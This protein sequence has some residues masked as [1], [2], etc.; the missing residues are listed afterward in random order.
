MPSR[1]AYIKAIIFCCSSFLFVAS[2]WSQPDNS[3]V[4]LP[5]TPTAAAFGKFIEATVAGHTGV[6]DISIP[7]HTVTTGPLSL[8]ISLRYN[9]SGIK[10]SEVASWV[11]IGW[12]LT[13]GGVISRTVNGLPDE[14]TNG[15][16]TEASNI[17]LSGFYAEQVMLGNKDSE[18]DIFSFSIPGYA[19]KMLFDENGDVYTIP[20][21]PLK[22][23]YACCGVSGLKFTISDPNGTRYIFGTNTNSTGFVDGRELSKNYVPTQQAPSD[24]V[25]S[26]MLIRMESYDEKH[27]IEFDYTLENIEYHMPGQSTYF[28]YTP[29]GSTSSNANLTNYVAS[30]RRLTAI[31]TNIGEEITF[32]A[33]TVRDDVGIS[34]Q[35]PDAHALDAITI[36]EGAYATQWVFSYDY[37]EDPDQEYAGNPVAKRLRLTQIQQKSLDNSIEIPPYV[38]DYSKKDGAYFLPQ[39]LSKAKDYWGYYNARTGNEN[40]LV[41]IPTTSIN[42]FTCSNCGSNRSSALNVM[43]YGVLEKITYPTGGWTEFTFEENRYKPT[44]SSPLLPI[45]TQNESFGVGYLDLETC[46]DRFGVGCCGSNNDDDDLTLS[47]IEDIYVELFLDRTVQDD[48]TCGPSIEETS[49]LFEVFRT[50]DDVLMGS[51]NLGEFD[52]EDAPI[53]R[54]KILKLIDLIPSLQNSV[55]YTYKLTSEDAYGTATLY[56][57]SY[58]IT[59]VGSESIGD[60]NVV[61]GLRAQEIRHYDP[62]QENEVVTTYEYSDGIL[63]QEY[64]TYAG[65]ISG[66]LVYNP[67]SGF[68]QGNNI[69][70]AYFS[71]IPT[72]P[73]QDLSGEHVGYEEI[74]IIQA[75]G[76]KKTR[77][78]LLFPD[79]SAYTDG[80]QSYN[81]LVDATSIFPGEIPPSIEIDNGWN[82]GEEMYKFGASTPYSQTSLVRNT[83]MNFVPEFTTNLKFYRSKALT[84]QVSTPDPNATGYLHFQYVTNYYS[85]WATRPSSKTSMLDGVSIVEAYQYDT[86]DNH[87]F[88]TEVHTANSDGSVWKQISTYPFDYVDAVNSER[89]TLNIIQPP[90]EVQILNDADVQVDGTHKNFS[91]FDGST[92]EV[93]GGTG[94]GPYL[95]DVERY[96]VSWD[97]NGTL[98]GSAQYNSIATIDKIDI[99]NGFPTEITQRGWQVD[100]F[101][102]NAD[103]NLLA[104]RSFG[105]FDW[106]YEY[107]TDTRLLSKVTDPDKQYTTFDYD[108]LRRLASSDARLGNVSTAYDY[109]YQESGSARNFI[110][111]TTTFTTVTGSQLSSLMDRNYLDGL[112]RSIQKIAVGQSPDQKDVIRAMTYDNVGRTLKE[113]EPYENSSASGAYV[114]IVTLDNANVDFTQYGYEDGPTN[115]VTE[116]TPPGWYTTTTSYGANSNQITVPG[117]SPFGLNTLF[118][119]TTTDPD[120]RVSISYKDMRGRLVLSRRNDTGSAPNIDTY[121]DYDDKDRLRTVYPPATSISTDS[122][123][124]EYVYDDRDN[125]IFKKIPDQDGMHYLYNN[126]NLLTFSQDGNMLANNHWLHTKYDTYGRPVSTGFVNNGNFAD[127]GSN[128][129]YNEELS[130]SFYDGDVGAADI[131]T[132]KI[133]KSEA[134]ILGTT[135]DW[136]STKFDYDPYGRVITTEAKNHLN[137]LDEDS[138]VVNMSYDFADNILSQNRDHKGYV[139]SPLVEIDES[140]TY[141]HA[142]RNTGHSLNLNNTGAIQLCALEYTIKNELKRKKMGGT[143][144]DFL[145]YVDYHYLPNGFLDRINDFSLTATGEPDDLFHL[146]LRYNEASTP[147]DVIAQKNGNISQV[148]WRVSG[149]NAKAY[150]FSYDYLNRLE[151]ANY[152]A[153]QNGTSTSLQSDDAYSSM[154]EY[155]QR[156]NIEWLERHGL[157][158]DGSNFTPGIIDDLDHKYS[159]TSNRLVTIIASG[160]AGFASLGFDDQGQ[161]GVYTYDKN[162][163]MQ[164]DPFKQLD[165]DYNHLNL[166]E[167]ITETDDSG[168]I[169]WLYDASGT[170]L[171][172]TTETSILALSG[173][174]TSGNYEAEEI[175]ASGIIQ[176]GSIVSFVADNEITLLPGFTTKSGSEFTA[177]LAPTGPTVHDYINGIE[178]R[179]GTLE[180]IYHDQGRIYFHNGTPRF[181][182]TITDHLGNTRVTFADLNDDDQVDETEVLQENHYYPFGLEML[183]DWNVHPYKQNQYQYNGKELNEDLG[184]NWLDYGARWY[185]PAIARWNAV[186]PLAEKM[187]NWS[188]YNYTY[189]NPIRFIDPIGMAPFGDLYNQSGKKIGTDNKDDGRV[190]VVT[191]KKTIKSLKKSGGVVADASQVNSAIELPTVAVRGEMG[192]AVDR[193]NSRNDNRTDE[194]QGDDNEG[195]FHEEGGVYGKDVDGNYQVIHAKPGAKTEPDAGAMA[196]VAPDDPANP[197]APLIVREGSF[198]VHPSGTR[199][200][201]SST[202][203]G[204][205]RS[206]NQNPTDP[207]DFNEASNYPGNSYVLGAKGT[208]TIINGSGKLATFPLKK[209]IN[210]GNGKK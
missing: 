190:F 171:R 80:Y 189:N 138:E 11:G 35:S 1:S 106:F 132:G 81:G 13:A 102:Y 177:N 71:D 30:T 36:T 126:R 121:Y 18:Q 108:V 14:E 196:T 210:I 139:A 72:F 133:W 61:G 137:L 26:W 58:N 198:H 20:K 119:E 194:F 75:D 128:P 120:N 87:P 168:S 103:N 118:K 60:E 181:E 46:L 10:V 161:T 86:N 200:P 4:S 172:K 23:E 155:D 68:V 101:T 131:F 187:S 199:S 201:G 2:I 122:L 98:N 165:I 140:W 124:Y 66:S 92:G 69:S 135:S 49:I 25:S 43:Q 40:N 152:G 33:N 105:D 32:T 28:D 54:T 170:K 191:D 16:L 197:N 12:N 24:I 78:F 8:P 115:R 209:F 150:G 130:R 52:I 114:S 19:G 207:Q 176:D 175:N 167:N 7:I 27:W 204:Q 73:L 178:Y 44:I 21:M 67:G 192:K 63:F 174:I 182:Y 173:I 146:D 3:Y 22:I 17:S 62:V 195:G 157:K 112:G 202:I 57:P 91:F 48:G 90:V 147:L 193:S 159:S 9:A 65:Q 39:R 208:V 136:L 142:G 74:H 64:P 95:A 141:D 185:D 143:G 41:N 169:E 188:P 5:P 153:Y 148:H 117:F 164:H 79:V 145:Q 29:G 55:E 77:Q 42:G 203:G 53:T 45:L 84:A 154:Y 50:S 151:T 76:G 179:D 206:F 166:P 96:E 31:R 129:N 183:G 125:I 205:T 163:N 162:G 160:D 180:A 94:I 99:N 85:H 156:G 6:P 47:N 104:S 82:K 110:E 88:P 144:S 70:G 116:V 59:R 93:V 107:E 149:Q 97:E 34:T 111:S 83:E 100:L 123:I 134:K 56:V 38:F 184:L 158:A 89:K 51:F 37:F 113:Y 127:G 15:F 109:V 186:D